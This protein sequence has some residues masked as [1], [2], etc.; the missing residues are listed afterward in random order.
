[1]NSLEEEFV[2][3]VNFI[4]KQTHENS[5]SKGW[6][7]TDRNDGEMIALIH[8]ELSEALEALRAGGIMSDHIPEFKGVEEELADAVIRIFDMSAARG[9]RLGEAIVAKMEF[10]QTRPHR[11]GGKAF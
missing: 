5:K 3:A 2:D 8:S 7:A 1:M 10:N 4:S 11:H 9:Y 6:W